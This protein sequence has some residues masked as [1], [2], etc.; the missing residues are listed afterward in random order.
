MRHHY[1]KNK[2]IV[3]T[4]ASSG[5]GKAVLKKLSEVDCRII[6]LSRNLPVVPKNSPAVIIPISCD[7]G[8]KTSIAKACKI[9]QKNFDK[10]DVLFNNAGITAHGRFDETSMDVFRKTFEVNFFGMIDLTQKLLPLLLKS[11]GTI[12]VTSSVQGLYGI[13][14]RSAYC[15]TKAALHSVF[16]SFRMEFSREGLRAILFCPSYTNTN[17]RTSGLTA[18]GSK[19]HDAQAKQLSEPEEVAS[20]MIKAVESPNSR[21]VIMEKMGLF[22]KWMRVISPG[23]M[24]RII[25]SKLQKDIERRKYER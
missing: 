19:L 2:T 15:S 14:G 21:L 3:I 18:K 24:E 4:G 1:W 12:I 25:F 16:E 22:V 11:R 8:S 17:L 23:L 10:V 9:I 5:I 20:K 7:I 13:P 6:T